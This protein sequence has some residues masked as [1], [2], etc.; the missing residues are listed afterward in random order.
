MKKVI[1]ILACAV[2][3]C[4]LSSCG[5]TNNSGNA[6]TNVIS[7]TTEINDGTS[8]IGNT[9]SDDAFAS[10]NTNPINDYK[11]D[12]QSVIN[13]VPEIQKDINID[14]IESHIEEEQSITDE[15]KPDLYEG[16][17]S[18]YDVNEPSLEI[19][20]NNDET[21]QIQIKIYRLFYL[22]DGVGKVTEEGLEF[23]ATGP[24]GNKVN[25]VIRLEE[26]IATVTFFSQ[27][28][29]DFAGLNEYKFYKTS[30]VP[31][32]YVYE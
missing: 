22:D 29:V 19:K 2:V 30:N 11:G 1:W 21:Y 26:D 20:K 31:N 23:V 12:E 24:N 6:Q 15:A 4:I 7:R 16:E 28:W 25:G 14:S 13:E 18:D 10:A 3:M 8:E 27:E 5:Q 17:Y 9:Q 32:I